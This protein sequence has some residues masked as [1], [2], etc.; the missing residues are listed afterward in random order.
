M[1]PS[2][3]ELRKKYAVLDDHDKLTEVLVKVEVIQQKL[4]GNGGPG[5]CERLDDVEKVT[6]RHTV[7]FAILVG[8]IPLA[9]YALDKL[10]R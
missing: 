8:A 2:E 9:I 4:G 7:Y 3:H 5:V 10:L 6:D 1:A